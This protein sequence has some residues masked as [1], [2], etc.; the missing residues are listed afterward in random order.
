MGKNLQ[1]IVNERYDIN[2]TISQRFDLYRTIIKSKEE[3]F[4]N[5]PESKD[6]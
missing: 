1:S 6:S 5:V 2:K 3:Y 4:K